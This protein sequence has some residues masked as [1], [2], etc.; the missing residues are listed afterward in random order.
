[1]SNSAR[2]ALA[3]HS[4]GASFSRAFFSQLACG[5]VNQADHELMSLGKSFTETDGKKERTIYSTLLCYY[6]YSWRLSAYRQFW[7]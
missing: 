7:I 1:M 4:M 3:K 6:T 5:E 2:A